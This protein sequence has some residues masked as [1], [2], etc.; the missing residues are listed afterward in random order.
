MLARSDHPYTEDIR[1]P[2]SEQLRAGR[3]QRDGIEILAS[4]DI[5][6]HRSGREVPL[7]TV[8]EQLNVRRRQAVSPVGLAALDRG[9]DR[10]VL[11]ADRPEVRVEICDPP[12]RRRSRG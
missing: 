12:P 9:N 6:R 7:H 1:V 4:E 2:P 3:K 10:V 8:A 5:P 11:A